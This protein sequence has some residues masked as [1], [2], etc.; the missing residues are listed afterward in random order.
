[1]T[2]SSHFFHTAAVA[3]VGAYPPAAGWAPSFFGSSRI[4]YSFVTVCIRS[5]SS[6]LVAAFPVIGLVLTNSLVGPSYYSTN[7][8]L[9]ASLVL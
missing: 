1:M 8:A 2:S 9:V 5:F 7:S 3:S 4:I 6:I